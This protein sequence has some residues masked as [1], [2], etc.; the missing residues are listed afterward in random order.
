MIIIFSFNKLFSRIPPLSPKTHFIKINP[1]N[2]GLHLLNISNIFRDNRLTSIISKYLEN[3]LLFVIS[4]TNKLEISFSTRTKSLLTLMFGV[5]FIFFFFCF[6]LTCHFCI[7]LQATLLVSPTKNYGYFLRKGLNA[8]FNPGFILLNAGVLS[9][10]HF[11]LNVNDGVRRKASEC[12]PLRIYQTPTCEKKKLSFKRPETCRVYW[13]RCILW[14]TLIK[15]IP[16]ESI[17]S[18]VPPKWGI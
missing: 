3:L 10:K 16:P 9:R 7:H 11:R 2:Q 8:Y 4:T 14:I 18:I 1:I 17:S 5:L 13:T 15:S 12:K 6:V